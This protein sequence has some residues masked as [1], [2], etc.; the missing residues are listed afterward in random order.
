MKNSA[1]PRSPRSPQLS[2]EDLNIPLALA[3]QRFGVIRVEVAGELPHWVT[4]GP[5]QKQALVACGAPS[6]RVWT[7]RE[8]ESLPWD[9]TPL[10]VARCLAVFGP[11]ARHVLAPGCAK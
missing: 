11:T 1:N 8:L 3:L 7:V 6:P 4:A 2:Q 9:E 5:R 10:T